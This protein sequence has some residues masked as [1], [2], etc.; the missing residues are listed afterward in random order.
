MAT[1]FHIISLIK[2]SFLRLWVVGMFLCLSIPHAVAQDKL[3]PLKNN[4]VLQD[5]HKAA[6]KNPYLKNKKGK[7]T[8]TVKLPFFDDFS[9]YTGYPNS[10]LWID[11]DVYINTGMATYPPST[12]VATFDGLNSNGVA[13]EPGSAAG[14]LPSDTLTSNYIDLSSYQDK[15]SIYL[16]FYYQPQGLGE[17]PDAEDT[18]MLEFKTDSSK[19]IQVWATPGGLKSGSPFKEVLVPVQSVSGQNYFYNK[20]QFR[21]RNIANLSGNLDIW[22]LDYIYL[23]NNRTMKD[24]GSEDVAIYEPSNSLVKYYTSIPWKHYINDTTDYYTDSIHDYTHYNSSTAT[25]HVTFHYTIKSLSENLLLAAPTGQVGNFTPNE[26]L[27]YELGADHFKK[28]TPKNTDSVVM[29]VNTIATNNTTGEQPYFRVNDTAS[30][31]QNFNTY[32]AYDDGTA[33]TGYG[34]SSSPNGGSVAV[35][36]NTKMPDSLFGIGIHFNQGG[37][38]VSLDYVNLEVWDVINSA[39]TANTK[40]HI[41]GQISGVFPQYI[42]QENGFFYFPFDKPIPV[43]TTFY[44]GWSQISDFMLDVGFDRNFSLTKS[45]NDSIL[46]YNING[47][48]TKSSQIGIPMIRAFVGKKPVFFTGVENE[49]NQE[50]A[51]PIQLYPNPN[52]GIFNI[53]LPEDGK[54][55]FELTD[56]NGKTILT[57]TNVNSHMVVDAGNYSPGIYIAHITSL[58]SGSQ[59]FKKVVIY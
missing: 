28:F 57:Q 49:K 6:Q 37:T 52:T 30:L 55:T 47:V 33:E 51:F 44:L 26:Y 54:F 35:Q 53:I 42:R 12:G 3:L 20:F 9:N 2:N 46:F 17:A 4:A 31:I 24:T 13:Y 45:R 34:I 5:L 7:D 56:I 21:F 18:F 14:D 38:D 50:S 41:I 58:Q 29:Q 27:D 40:D 59:V 1:K 15:D 10:A 25:T 23:K 36:F 39:N 48:W 19:W 16:S 22:N 32:F 11:N 8:P 43:G